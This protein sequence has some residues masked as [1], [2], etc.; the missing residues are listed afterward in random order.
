MIIDSDSHFMPRDAFD[1]LDD[2][3]LAGQAPRL[4]IDERGILQDI[5]FALPNPPGTTPLPPPGSGSHYLGNMDLEARG[6]A[7]QGVVHVVERVPWREVGIGVDDHV[8]PLSLT[9]TA[10]LRRS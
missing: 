6:Q 1:Y 5:R 3:A 2:N 10:K 7:C 8:A 4:E 9:G